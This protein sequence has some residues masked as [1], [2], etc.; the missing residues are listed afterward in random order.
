M[1]ELIIHTVEISR[2][3]QI[4]HFQIPLA[5]NVQAITG[6]WYKIR[7]IDDATRGAIVTSLPGRS[8]YIPEVIVGT[9]SLSSNQREGVFYFGNLIL[10]D[11]NLGMLD[12]SSGVFPVKPYS[13][14]KFSQQ[15][16]VRIDGD[17]AIVQGFIE[18]NWGV[19]SSRDV[20]YEVD[21]Y[22]YQQL[23]DKE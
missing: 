4:R 9:L 1:E 18:D 10:E 8:V 16:G 21:I 6:L 22:I 5:N 17:T 2:R 12:F 11:A 19:L 15:L 7:L 20:R 23:K 14:K 13:H 3:A